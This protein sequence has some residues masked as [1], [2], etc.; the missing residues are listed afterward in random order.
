[1]FE[2]IKNLTQ[3]RQRTVVVAIHG[4]GRRRT[5][6][7]LPLKKVLQEK[8]I[9]LVMPELY[10]PS[11][12]HDNKA[13]DWIHR[14]EEAVDSLLKQNCR[15]ILV[16]HSMGGVIASHLAAVKPVS[17]LV[18]LAPAFNYIN[19]GNTARFS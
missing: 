1:M 4:F 9:E 8:K 3:P 5:D 16:G 19:L 6:A 13:E 7:F 14:A 10:N 15:V 18:L 11:D 2:F 17:K 12:P